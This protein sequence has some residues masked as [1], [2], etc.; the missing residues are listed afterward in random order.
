[1]REFVQDP[2]NTVSG[3]MSRIGVPGASP[4]YVSARAAASRSLGSV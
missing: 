2:M 3:R 4:M 1:M